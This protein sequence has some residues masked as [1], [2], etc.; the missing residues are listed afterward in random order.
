VLSKAVGL[1]SWM[2]AFVKTLADR[3]REAEER[4]ST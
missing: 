1:N 3:F 4:K 2:G